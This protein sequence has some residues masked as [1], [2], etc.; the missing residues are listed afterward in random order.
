MALSAGAFST[1]LMVRFKNHY[2]SSNRTCETIASLLDAAGQTRNKLRLFDGKVYGKNVF[3]QKQLPPAF[4]NSEVSTISGVK[5][6]C[7][8]ITSNWDVM[9]GVM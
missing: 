2:I 6:S 4:S 3:I 7:R 9:W 1:S 5:F 8:R